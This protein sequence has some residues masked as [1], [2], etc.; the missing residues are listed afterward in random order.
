MIYAL[1][2]YL[3]S[4][5]FGSLK[6]YL[7]DAKV[8]IGIKIIFITIS[9]FIFQYYFKSF[10]LTLWDIYQNG[11]TVFSP[12]ICVFNGVKD[13]IILI[14]FFIT[15]FFMSGLILNIVVRGKG[16]KLF[17][18]ISPFIILI[19]TLDLYIFSITESDLIEGGKTFVVFL[20]LVTI[21]IGLINLFYNIKPV[22]KLFK[23]NDN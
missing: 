15:S 20:G 13:S 9:F 14:L 4:V 6:N 19:T 2:I 22:Q 18:F 7:K 12:E 16:H 1:L 3:L 5:Y 23:Q 8:S 21:A 11:F 10:R 17:L